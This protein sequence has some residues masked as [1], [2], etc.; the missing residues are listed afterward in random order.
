MALQ[1]LP[2]HRVKPT[3]TTLAVREDMRASAVRV[4]GPA[5]ISV[6]LAC[7]SV[8]GC[9]GHIS[10]PDDAGALDARLEDA[11][12]PDAPI[13]GGSR[14]RHD[15][16]PDAPSPDAGP[17]P[18]VC[19]ELAIEEGEH[20]FEIGGRERRYLLYLPDGYAP[21]RQW[22]LLFAL[23]GNGGSADYW[24]RTEGA[25]NVREAV[26]ADAVLVIA[27]AIDGAWRDY[28]ADSSTWPGRIEEELD[29]FDAIVEA[30][31]D[32]LCIN[33]DAIFAMGFSGG[34][35]F[36]GLMACRR[37]YIRAFA[38]GGAVVYFDSDNCVQTT[39]AWITI[40]TEELVSGREAFRDYFRQAAG[41]ESTSTSTEPT[42]CVAYDGCDEGKPVHYCQHPDGHIWPDFGTTAMFEFLR[43]FD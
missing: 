11:Q 30:L 12:A 22:P 3:R 27:E 9:I 41:C 2:T 32:A 43:E 7:V 29:Y 28:E 37:E 42:P 36:A 33:D 24:N 10:A 39:P 6:G 15:A 23:H 38:A 1:P 18:I 14:S 16:S 31:R 19:P 20:L 35:S 25:R 26:A 17:A 5:C 8:A 4:V 40:G 21:D 34:G 13:D